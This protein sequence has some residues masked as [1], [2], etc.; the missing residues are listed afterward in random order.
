MSSISTYYNGHGVLI[1]IFLDGFTEQDIIANAILLFLAG[2]EPVSSTL[3]FCLYQLALN[4]NI[5]DKMREEMY[6]KSKQHGQL[7][8]DFLVDLYY[9][10][11]VLAG[12]Y[13]NI[14]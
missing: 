8:N 6:S 11:M 2:F 13:Q 10:D 4:Q 1:F 12:K 14:I 7:N 3:S 9:T 5:Q